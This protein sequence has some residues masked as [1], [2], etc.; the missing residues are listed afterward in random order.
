MKKNEVKLTTDELN[1]ILELNN[2]Y[3]NILINFGQLHIRKVHI[4]KEQE[5][6]SKLEKEYHTSYIEVEKQEKNFKDR[7]T[8]KYGEGEINLESGIYIRT[9]NNS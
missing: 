8:R 6:I 4:E 5:Q 1:E 3:Q 9:E 7:I 2:D